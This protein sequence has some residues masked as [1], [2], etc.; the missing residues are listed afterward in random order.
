M[1]FKELGLDKQLLRALEAEGYEHPTPIQEQAIPIVLQG[2]D[3]IACAQTGTG[4]TAAFSLPIL[5]YLLETPKPDADAPRTIR[6]LILSPTR[7]LSIQITDSIDTYGKHTRLR[8]A[9]LFGG[10]PAHGQLANLRHGADILI[11]TPGRLLD[12][13]NQGFVDLRKVEIFVLDEA[14]RMLD[15]GFIHDM[16]RIVAMLPKSRQTLLFSATMSP[17]VKAI[18]DQFLYKPL[19]ISVAPPKETRSAIEE[20]LYFVEKPAKIGLLRHLIQENG[21]KKGIVFTRTKYGADKLAKLLQQYSI[22][23]GA[24]HGNKSQ[25]E[26]QRVLNDF[27]R[28]RIHIL[29]ASDIAARGIDIDD[30]T[31]V[32]NYEIPEQAETYVHRIGRTGRAGSKGIAISFC[33]REERKYLNGVE[34]L[35]NKRLTIVE[36][37]PYNRTVEVASAD[38]GSRRSNAPYQGDRDRNRNYYSR[39]RR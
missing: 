9:L 27:R 17:E 24:I 34:K 37:H 4:K 13:A 26:R 21:I 2:D 20:K 5:Q 23:T 3:L 33:A 12:F 36:D 29:V 8:S 39:N 22:S 11:A 1:T 38:A 31:H 32:F 28:G 14:D 19:Q 15:M 7:E 25:N 6:A 10:I 35:T 30:I 16:K 18:A